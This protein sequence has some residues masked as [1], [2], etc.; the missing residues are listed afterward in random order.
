MSLCAVGITFIT[1]STRQASVFF[2]PANGDPA[3][4]YMVELMT[5]YDGATC[6]L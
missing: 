4:R 2:C 3:A 1:S 6:S 5:T